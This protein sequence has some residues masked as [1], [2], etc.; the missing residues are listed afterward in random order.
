MELGFLVELDGVMA[1][2]QAL[3]RQ[4]EVPLGLGRAL[5]GVRSVQTGD[6][7]LDA[8]IGAMVDHLDSVLGRL[9][10]ALGTDA[11]GLS[12][13]AENYRSAD[14]QVA[15]SAGGAASAGP[16]ADALTS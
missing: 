2:S 6:A 4:K 13:V 5:R 11:D 1:A 15:A 9:S 7:G 3:S 8:R 16:A 10:D 12:R 14:A